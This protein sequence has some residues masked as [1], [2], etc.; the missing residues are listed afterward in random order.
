MK[1]IISG[2]SGVRRGREI[3]G[4]P[5]AYIFERNKKKN[6]LK[7]F[8]IYITPPEM[9]HN[10]LLLPSYHFSPHEIVLQQQ[11][12]QQSNRARLTLSVEG[13]SSCPR[14]HEEGCEPPSLPWLHLGSWTWLPLQRGTKQQTVIK[15][16]F[17]K[18][19][20][21]NNA[22]FWLPFLHNYSFKK[23]GVCVC[24]PNKKVK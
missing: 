19:R 5:H 13:Q 10:P 7:F 20:N 2:G 14:Q 17:L 12:T 22:N 3:S 11:Q 9:F 18:I 1:P 23:K 24:I 16:Y 8:N 4:Q 15:D 21:H 6:Y